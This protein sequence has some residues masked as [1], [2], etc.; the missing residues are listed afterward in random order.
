[1]EWMVGSEKNGDVKDGSEASALR[2]QRVTEMVN[3]VGRAALGW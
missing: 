1:M 2:N 3:T